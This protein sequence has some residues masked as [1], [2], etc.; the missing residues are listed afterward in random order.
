MH[1]FCLHVWVKLSW[2]KLFVYMYTRMPCRAERQFLLTLQA[3]RYCLLAVQGKLGE[4]KGVNTHSRINN[5]RQ[6]VDKE[7]VTYVQTCTLLREAARITVR[8]INIRSYRS[9][10]ARARQWVALRKQICICEWHMSRGKIHRHVSLDKCWPDLCHIIMPELIHEDSV[11]SPNGGLTL[12]QRLRR[13]T[14][15]KP[16]LV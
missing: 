4:L 13:W 6:Y 7:A 9:D 14:N 12:V 8:D 10:S 16:T 15:V 2:L 5:V 11:H 1:P 3:G